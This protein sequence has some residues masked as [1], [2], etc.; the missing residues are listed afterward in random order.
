MPITPRL[1][2][3]TIALVILVILA[4]NS[5][6]FALV[7][8][9]FSEDRAWKLACWTGEWFWTY[10]QNHWEITLNA[11]EAVEVTGDEIPQK[12]SA[13][14]ITNHLGYSD[15]YLLQYLSCRAGMLGSSRYFVKKEILRIP[16]FGLAFWSMGM[17]LVSRDWTSDKRTLQDAFLRITSNSHPC[18]II[19][20]PEGTRRTPSKLVKSQAF[21]R[22]K[23][24]PELSHLLFPRSKGF[25]CTIQA[26]RHSHIKY[27]YDTTLLY[28]S[29]GKDKW[30]I[31][32]LAEQ[33][34]CEDMTKQ[35][36]KFRIHVKRIPISELP[37]GEKSLKEWC[38][39]K[40]K[41]K[42][43]LLDDWMTESKRANGLNDHHEQNG[44]I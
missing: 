6:L 12:E 23:G 19:M 14:I 3:H 43:D 16:F 24:K 11:K 27:V 33:L 38:E 31:P 13:M 35:G 20:C 28:S 29:P 37:E 2:K 39:E 7:I 15:Y 18:W 17:I 34:S 1:V 25:V 42:D 41:V 21:A 4:N 5:L 8:K 32:S 30:R 22:M 40:W 44:H 36:Y 26:L 10:M 9:P